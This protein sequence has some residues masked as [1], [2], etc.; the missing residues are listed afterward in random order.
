MHK[1]IF[2]TPLSMYNF[3]P[4]HLEHF[5]RKTQ[6]KFSKFLTQLEVFNIRSVM[7]EHIQHG[8]LKSI[9]SAKT[10]S[11]P[12][13]TLNLREQTNYT[14]DT[15]KCVFT[16]KNPNDIIAVT[17]TSNFDKNKDKLAC[18]SHTYYNQDNIHTT[19]PKVTS[20]RFDPTTGY[21]FNPKPQTLYIPNL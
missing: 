18:V 3:N 1:R 4:S 19:H 16:D 11:H 20:V 7:D 21:I 2:K 10:I 6:P 15:V 14:Y 8:Y 12:A 9:S 13:I 17:Q 5:I